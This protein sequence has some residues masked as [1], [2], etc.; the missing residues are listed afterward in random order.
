MPDSRREFLRHCSA[1]GFGFAVFGTAAWL[2]ACTA[3]RVIAMHL[4]PVDGVIAVPRARIE[5]M[6]FLTV[7]NSLHAEP[8]YVNLDLPASSRVAVLLKCTHKGCE[9][10]PAAKSLRCPCHGSLFS[11]EGKVLGPPA[12]EDLRLFKVTENKDHILIHIS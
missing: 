8:I 6:R 3:G 5:G 2:E 7:R 9:L 1:I 10:S 12:S 11:P 4:E